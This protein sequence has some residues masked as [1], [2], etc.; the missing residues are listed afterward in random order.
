MIR[1]IAIVRRRRWRR[2]G[3]RVDWLPHKMKEEE[4]VVVVVVVLVVVVMMMI[5]GR[6]PTQ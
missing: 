6:R 3:R 2:A 5:V 4:E 1:M